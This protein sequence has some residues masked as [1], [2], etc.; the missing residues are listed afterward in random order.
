MVYFKRGLWEEE[1]KEFIGWKDYGSKHAENIYTEFIGAKVLPKKFGID[2]RIVYLSAKVRSGFMDRRE[3]MKQLSEPSSFDIGKIPPA[4]IEDIGT[5]IGLREDYDRYDFKK[6]KW[7]I[8]LLWKF[9]VVP[10]T[11]YVKYCK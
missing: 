3:A 1:M 10:Q 2:K 8:W 9:Q 11:M 6:Y 7:V 5:N 4:I